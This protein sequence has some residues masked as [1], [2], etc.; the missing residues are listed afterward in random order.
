[1]LNYQDYQGP[2]YETII[3]IASPQA[4]QSSKV[5]ARRHHR[6]NRRHCE[7]IA[8]AIQDLILDDTYCSGL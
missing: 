7:A 1:M 4:W 5:V 3:V 6:F 8:V 2:T